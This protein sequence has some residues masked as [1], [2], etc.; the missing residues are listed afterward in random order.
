MNGAHAAACCDCM[1]QVSPVN[2]GGFL[3]GSFAGQPFS[4]QSPLV[5]AVFQDREDVL[6]IRL[7]GGDQAEQLITV[8]AQGATG[9]QD[10]QQCRDDGHVKA[11]GN[12][13]LL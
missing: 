6:H 13:V 3:C 8:N 9:A 5:F 10:H 11:Q 2:S 7:A 12:A 1:A 4:F